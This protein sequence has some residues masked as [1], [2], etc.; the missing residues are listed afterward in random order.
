M[1]PDSQEFGAFFMVPITAAP[2]WLRL[3]PWSAGS[4]PAMR[5]PFCPQP[6]RSLSCLK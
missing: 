6:A 1:A 5:E 3:C 4:L 2:V